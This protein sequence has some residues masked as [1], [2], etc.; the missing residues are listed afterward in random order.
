MQQMIDEHLLQILL[1]VNLPTPNQME[2][3]QFLN[4][5]LLLM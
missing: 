3:A 4:W 1:T 2:S 5:S